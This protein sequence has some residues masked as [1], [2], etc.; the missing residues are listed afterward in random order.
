M[1][2]TLVEQL[3]ATTELN[4]CVKTIYTLLKA[5][6]S[7]FKAKIFQSADRKFSFILYRHGQPVASGTSFNS[8]KE[9]VEACD[10]AA[11]DLNP[12]VVALLQKATE[13]REI[14]GEVEFDF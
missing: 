12:T 9:A 10:N 4:R 14:T 13:L 7:K 11:I 6:R 8:E 5:D 2:H 3:I 1:S